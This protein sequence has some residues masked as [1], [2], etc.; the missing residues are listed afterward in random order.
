MKLT[1][2]LAKHNL[3]AAEFG[4]R[5][6]VSRSQ[7]LRYLK[8]KRRITAERAI[9]IEHATDGAVTRADVRPDLFGEMRKA[10]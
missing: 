10:S 2:Y 5:I 3:T 4:R 9:E 8:G 7:M 6:N 1:D